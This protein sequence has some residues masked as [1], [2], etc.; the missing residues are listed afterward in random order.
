MS[1]FNQKIVLFIEPSDVA[2]KTPSK[3][4]NLF[5]NRFAIEEAASYEILK[6]YD[7]KNAIMPIPPSFLRDEFPDDSFDSLSDE[8]LEEGIL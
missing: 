4:G 6:I 2:W 8:T 1:K 5:M 3:I 7:F